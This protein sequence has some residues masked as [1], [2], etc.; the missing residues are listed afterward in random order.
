MSTPQPSAPATPRWY[1]RPVF[2]VTDVQ[3]AL[4]FYVDQLG[5]TKAWHAGDGAGTVCQVNH[6]ECEVILCEDAR[7]AGRGRLFIELTPEA[8]D[9]WR[10]EVS[11]R[12]IP[13]REAWWGYDVLQLDDPDGNE[14]M[15][16][17]A[18]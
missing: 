2:F 13:S 3:R 8:L 1:A 17:E 9:A 14:L 16:P 7:R 5:F 12:G 4:R 18:T 10:R 15:F 11:A 6:G